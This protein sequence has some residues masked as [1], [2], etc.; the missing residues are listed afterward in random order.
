MVFQVLKHHFK[1]LSLAL[2]QH[3]HLEGLL[4]KTA[5]A[6]L[7]IYYGTT[8]NH[9]HLVLAGLYLVCQRGFGSTWLLGLRRHCSAIGSA[10]FEL[11]QRSGVCLDDNERVLVWQTEMAGMACFV[12]TEGKYGISKLI[13]HQNLWYVCYEIHQGLWC[14]KDTLGIKISCVVIH[15]VVKNRCKG[16]QIPANSHMNE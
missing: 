1:A 15:I 13:V 16:R 8:E 14:G 12:G 9:F 7:G 10:G 2:C 4:H 11:V 5:L 6:C 3:F